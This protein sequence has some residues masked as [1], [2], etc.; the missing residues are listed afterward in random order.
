[1]QN[2]NITE[3]GLITHTWSAIPELKTPY[4]YIG[5]PNMFLAVFI[6]LQNT[7]IFLDCYRDRARIAR[8]LYLV[9]ALTDM[10]SAVLELIRDGVSLSCLQGRIQIPAWT[11][12][13]YLSMG[14]SCYNCSISFNVILAVAKTINITQ[15]F[16]RIEK[17]AVDM[18]MIAAVVFWLAVGVAD[19]LALYESHKSAHSCN[20]QWILLFGYSY[21]GEGLLARYCDLSLIKQSISYEIRP[22]SIPMVMEY[23]VPCV[24]VFVCTA[25]QMVHIK[26]SFSRSSSPQQKLANHVNLTVF[27]V[28]VTFLLS[29][30][31]F[32]LYCFVPGSNLVLFNLINPVTK[33]SEV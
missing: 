27:L 16:Y 22:S 10:F 30:A 20:A 4:P 32:C 28:C 14:L 13:W 19:I 24:V 6:L 18:L 33:C 29:V 26:K 3:A 9:I 2:S 17:K 25:I 8:R 1:M 21:L 11:V 31:A 5:P 15:P 7:V 12:V 23:L